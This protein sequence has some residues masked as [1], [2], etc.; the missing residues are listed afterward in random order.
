[1]K[2]G[3]CAPY[4]EVARLKNISF[5]YLEE[6]VRRFLLPEQSQETFEEVWR[7]TRVLPIPIEAANNLLP[8]SLPLVA[9]PTQQVDTAR[10]EQYMKTA[11]RRA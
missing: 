7:E 11:L 4:S 3:I 9:T 6:N 10:L 8:P 1:M 5:D 2:F